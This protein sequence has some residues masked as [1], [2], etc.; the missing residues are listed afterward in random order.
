MMVL[1]WCGRGFRRQALRDLWKGLGDAQ[2]AGTRD[3]GPTGPATS[4]RQTGEIAETVR[5]APGR[6]PR[7]ARFIRISRAVARPKAWFLAKSRSGG[8]LASAFPTAFDG[9]RFR[10]ICSFVYHTNNPGGRHGA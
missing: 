3:D 5:S 1:S 8:S 4:I 9:S 2:K 10:L 7:M 6:N